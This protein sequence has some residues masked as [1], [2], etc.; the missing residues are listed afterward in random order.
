MVLTQIGWT[1]IGLEILLLLI[2]CYQVWFTQQDDP[3]GKGLAI[4]FLLALAGYTL[5]G[6]VLMLFRSKWTTV[7]AVVMGGLPLAVV[8]YGLSN[9]WKNRSQSPRQ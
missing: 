3:A 4:P 1:I 7:T 9:Y 6:I 8:V 2:W 5:V